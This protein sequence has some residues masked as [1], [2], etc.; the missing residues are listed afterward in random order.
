MANIIED[1]SSYIA[2]NITGYTE[3]TNLFYGSHPQDTIDTPYIVIYDMGGRTN[4]YA[5]NFQF[6]RVNLKCYAS[7]YTE[8][9]NFLQSI[10]NILVNQVMTFTNFYIF[11]CEVVN[12][13][14]LLQ[15][16]SDGVFE[17][18]L[19]LDLRIKET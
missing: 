6:N 2:A 5:N 8:G 14:S 18:V 9:F 15:H 4:R 19:T 11:H 16:R 17:F 7:S 3:G 13:T 10:E 1:L 12:K